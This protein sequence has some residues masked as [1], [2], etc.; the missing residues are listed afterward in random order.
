MAG[1]PGQRILDSIT[2]LNEKLQGG[3]LHVFLGFEAMVITLEKGGEIRSGMCDYPLPVSMNANTI[4]EI[5]RYLHSLPDGKAP[6]RSP[7]RTGITQ[8]S[9]IGLI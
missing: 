2:F 7:P 1:A 6:I 8:R 3:S 5:S 4:V 9:T